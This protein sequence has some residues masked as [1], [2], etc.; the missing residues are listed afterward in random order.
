MNRTAAGIEYTAGASNELDCLTGI[1]G[2]HT[3]WSGH[4]LD[5]QTQLRFNQ[6]DRVAAMRAQL[7]EFLESA[8]RFE[9]A[10]HDKRLSAAEQAMLDAL[11]DGAD[12][13]SL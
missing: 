5:P 1:N 9:R 8:P 12:G 6:R 10:F 7:D 2:L 3:I 13:E 11:G 4:K